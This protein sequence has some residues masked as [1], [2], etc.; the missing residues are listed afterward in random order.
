[1]T[2]ARFGQGSLLLGSAALAALSLLGGCATFGS[3]VRGSFSCAAP[4]GIC[5][6]SSSIDDRALAMIAGEGAVSDPSPASAATR[7]SSSKPSRTASAG[8]VVPASPL[9]ARRI[10]ER[11]LRIV[12]Q[13]YIDERGRLHEAS[14]V[15]AVVQSGE[16]QQQA[17]A[18]AT[19]IP[20]Q[21]ALTS[22]PQPE[23]LAD[24]VDRAD[25]ATLQSGGS[26][27]NLPDPA[28]VAAARARRADP[29][30]AIQ[31]DVAARLAPKAGRTP[32]APVME[33][34]KRRA[35]TRSVEGEAPAISGA[36][37]KADSQ[38]Q[39][40]VSGADTRPIAAPKTTAAAEAI[41]RVKASPEFK[42][43]AAEA[44]SE[45]RAAGQTGA[46][47]PINVN[48]QPTVRAAGFPAAVPEDN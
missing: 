42:A 29:V 20:E 48:V 41:A 31:D 1:M 7:R 40:P 38:A 9:D 11:V 14:A 4:D 27:P 24:A 26:D 30:K 2:A 46:I 39:K 19:S 33:I 44:E 5:A 28:V 32:A 22:G 37:V 6:P 45:A 23:S 35:E 8:P 43:R 13:P 25:L 12:F 16:W 17:L 3:N 18:N 47:P 21:N 15:H 34:T 36:K 10:Q